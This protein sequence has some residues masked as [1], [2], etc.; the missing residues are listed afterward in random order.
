[1]VEPG[2]KPPADKRLSLMERQ[3]ALLEK[4]GFSKPAPASPGLLRSSQKKHGQS[5]PHYGGKQSA[6]FE[7]QDRHLQRSGQRL[8]ATAASR[9][10]VPMDGDGG[11][12]G[13]GL[14]EPLD[15]ATNKQVRWPPH[16]GGGI[17]FGSMA[18]TEGASPR[19][20]AA[21]QNYGS[22]LTVT[23]ATRR[24]LPSSLHLPAHLHFEQDQQESAEVRTTE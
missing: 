9:T 12:G 3:Q 6:F 21:G 4:Q 24:P 14:D 15:A 8:N 19:L 5:Q 20:V 13:D 2:R 10:A 23:N 17:L 16:L 22:N 18:V 1:M 11:G 7:R